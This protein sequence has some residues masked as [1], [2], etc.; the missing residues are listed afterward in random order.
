MQQVGLD[1]PGIELIRR[2]A[3]VLGQCRHAGQVG[4]PCAQRQPAQDHGI[5]HP[6]AQFSH[7]VLLVIS[8]TFPI[9]RIGQSASRKAKRGGDSRH[10]RVSGLVQR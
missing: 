3:V 6:L 1:L 2:S 8:G 4:L 9:A 10:H 7:V 5:I